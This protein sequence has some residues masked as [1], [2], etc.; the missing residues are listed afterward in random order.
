MTNHNTEDFLPEP[1]QYVLAHLNKD[2]WGDSD[3]P[4]GNRYWVVV[5]FIK[6]I[7]ELE[8]SMLPDSAKRKNSYHTGDV[9]GNNEK[10]YEWQ[11]FGP[12]K[13]FGQDVDFWCELPSNKKENK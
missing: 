8:R 3:D 12:S 7:S 11:E 13:Y 9:H 1:N 2:N 5:K 4:D 6:G 10:P